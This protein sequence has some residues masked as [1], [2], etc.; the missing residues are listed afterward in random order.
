MFLGW[1][2]VKNLMTAHQSSKTTGNVSVDVPKQQP[3]QAM[4]ARLI[5]SVTATPDSTKINHLLWKYLLWH[6]RNDIY[7]CIAYVF[8][9]I[10]LSFLP[11]ASFGLRVLS[12]PA[13]VCVCV[14]VCG[15]HLLVRA[16]TCHLFKLESPN[17]DQKSKTPW[18]RSLLFWGLIDLELQG[19]INFKVKNCHILSL[20]MPSFTIYPR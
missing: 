13:S 11:K 16:I 1:K 9:M 10:S 15:N 5:E 17:L 8:F 12:L 6:I 3:S 4:Q 19:Q 18:L 20:S 14:C 2:R 7:L